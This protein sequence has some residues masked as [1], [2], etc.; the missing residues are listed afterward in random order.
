MTT[1]VKICGLRRRAQLDAAVEAGADMVG[2]VFFDRSPRVV[3]LEDAAALSARVPHGVERVA[4]VVDADD[5]FLDAVI[6]PGVVDVLQLHGGET[7]ERCAHIRARYGL[8]VMKVLGVATA[9][10]VMRIDDYAASVD[11]FLFDT[12]PPKGATRPGGNAVAFDWTVLSGA[13]VPK[14]WLLA[15]GLTPDTVADAIRL[16]GAPGVDVSSGVENAPGEKDETLVRAFVANAKAGA[17]A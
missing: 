6:G 1:R 2:F 7:P 9:D 15:G 3:T 12:K 4:L 13:D 17:A 8:P 11:R 14:P 10:D 5:A 16:S